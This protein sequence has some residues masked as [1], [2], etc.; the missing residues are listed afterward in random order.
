MTMMM[1]EKVVHINGG[2]ARARVVRIR[3]ARAERF[4][5]TAGGITALGLSKFIRDYYNRHRREFLALVAVVNLRVFAE[6][7]LRLRLMIILAIF[8]FGELFLIRRRKYRRMKNYG[9]SKSRWHLFTA[10]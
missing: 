2:V 4:D 6:P 1:A 3:G 7:S 9:R 8:F 10:R 5:G